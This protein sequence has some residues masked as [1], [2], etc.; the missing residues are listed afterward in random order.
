MG[1]VV[2]ALRVGGQTISSLLR[3]TPSVFYHIDD[4][5]TRW[6]VVDLDEASDLYDEILKTA[7]DVAEAL[8]RRH[9]ISSVIRSSHL[10]LIIDEIYYT[11]ISIILVFDELLRI[12][13]DFN[14]PFGGIPT[15]ASGDGTQFTPVLTNVSFA[16]REFLLKRFFHKDTGSLRLTNPYRQVS[17]SQISSILHNSC[18]L[19]GGCSISASVV[20]HISL[21][22]DTA[23]VREAMGE[24][25]IGTANSMHEFEA[26][27]E[28]V[29]SDYGSLPPILLTHRNTKYVGTL[30]RQ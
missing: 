27:L 7:K 9:G 6:K 17:K 19:Q 4:L 30:N 24:R 12:F 10:V 26:L 3:A 18:V 2:S 8:Q 14:R 5:V 1:R 29:Q 13:H 28:K 21:G 25:V 11:S 16:S 20:S 22:V 23:D 15:I